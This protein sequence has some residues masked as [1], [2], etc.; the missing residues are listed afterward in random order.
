MNL[1]SKRRI[2]RSHWKLMKTSQLIINT[3]NSLE[4]GGPADDNFALVEENVENE[5]PTETSSTS[6]DPPAVEQHMPEE[7]RSE[8][9]EQLE[10][11]N[12]TDEQ[13]SV[14]VMTED[15]NTVGD[16]NNA[17][18]EDSAGNDFLLLRHM[19]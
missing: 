10:E 19:E 13:N 4:S 16:N 14:E 2:R 1:I 5:E 8:V 18:I 6:N 7:L 11:T 9:V 12:I 17:G 15:A 3:M